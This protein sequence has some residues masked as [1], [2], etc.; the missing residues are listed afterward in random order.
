MH[1]V[2]PRRKEERAMKIDI[3]FDFN[4]VAKVDARD[5]GRLITEGK[6]LGFRRTSGWVM[7]GRDAVR[8][9]EGDYGGPER[10]NIM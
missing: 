9:R 1:S 8:G 2:R 5:L 7:R 10:R 4:A 6:I 3:M